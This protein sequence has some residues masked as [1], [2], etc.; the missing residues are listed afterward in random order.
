VSSRNVTPV[1]GVHHADVLEDS[2]EVRQ[3]CRAKTQEIGVTR[4]AMW[5]VEPQAEQ[6]R[7]FQQEL[8]GVGGDAEPVQQT[9]EGIAGQDE[10]EVL[11]GL[12]SAVEQTCPHGSREVSSGHD[13]L[14][15]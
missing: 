9:L 2:F 1:R 14:S 8:T 10:I 13:R 3:L 5:N 15:M 4:R 12:A 6:Q 7:P 11:P